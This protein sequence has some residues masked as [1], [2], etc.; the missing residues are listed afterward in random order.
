MTERTVIHKDGLP[1]RLNGRL[2]REVIRP[3]SGLIISE[4]IRNDPHIGV[5]CERDTLDNNFEE[6]KRL[7]IIA[8]AASSKLV[9]MA[10]G[11]GLESFCT[12]VHGS[13]AR[14]LVRTPNCGDPSDIDIDLVIHP[15]KVDKPE[16]DRVREKMFRLSPQFGARIDTY[17]WDLEQMKKNSSLFARW[18]IASSAFSLANRGNLWEKVYEAG[19]ESQIFFQSLS[20][21]QRQSIQQILLMVTEAT[22][23]GEV[24]KL[25]ASRGQVVEDFLKRKILVE[26]GG[27]PKVRQKAIDYLSIV[28][29]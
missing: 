25:M 18:Y 19:V 7:R 16:R 28:S 23:L 11:F 17:V 24:L 13:V 12:V 21:K 22:R 10:E 26:E 6:N 2:R 29:R 27:F 15:S 4:M 20:K 1:I 5:R 3:V 8:R 14:G 9:D